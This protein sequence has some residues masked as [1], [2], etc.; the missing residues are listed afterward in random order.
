MKQ[1]QI[2]SKVNLLYTFSERFNKNLKNAFTE[3]GE[4]IFRNIIR[5]EFQKCLFKID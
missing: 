3:S 5:Y 1:Y 4:Y 2:L